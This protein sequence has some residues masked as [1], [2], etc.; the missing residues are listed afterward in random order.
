MGFHLACST[1]EKIDD[2]LSRSMIEK[3][4]NGKDSFEDIRI[5]SWAFFLKNDV[6]VE[7]WRGTKSPLNMYYCRAKK[8]RLRA[9]LFFSHL[10]RDEA[11]EKIQVLH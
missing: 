3:L 2:Q 5:S 6:L 7:T 4:A 1:R 10:T 9:F 8:R 11:I